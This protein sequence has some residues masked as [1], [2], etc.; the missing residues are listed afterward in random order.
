VHSNRKC[1]EPEAPSFCSLRNGTCGRSLICRCFTDFRAWTG[2]PGVIAGANDV[3]KAVK[4]RNP[5]TWV[6]RVHAKA[7]TNWLEGLESVVNFH[8]GQRHSS[9]RKNGLAVQGGQ[10]TEANM[11]DC[12]HLHNVRNNL[13][14]F[15]HTTTPFFLIITVNST[16]ITFI[17]QIGT[18]VRKS[19]SSSVNFYCAHYK[20]AYIGALRQF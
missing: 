17:T 20:H 13:H 7:L 2:S 8:Q 9:G 3:T 19:S 10:K 5:K 18:I 12:R 1:P 6:S 11:F 15:W 16:M 4:T 14:D